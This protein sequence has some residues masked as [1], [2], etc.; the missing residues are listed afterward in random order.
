M[1]S[2][3]DHETCGILASWLRIEPVPP[4]PAMNWKA[5]SQALDHQGSVIKFLIISDS[6]TFPA[7]W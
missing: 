1:F 6:A 4:A 7:R 2:F 3:F 5:K